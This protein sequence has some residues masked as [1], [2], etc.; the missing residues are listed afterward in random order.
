MLI[1]AQGKLI[2]RAV[3]RALASEANRLTHEV[4]RN[5]P[6]VRNLPEPL[7]PPCD[8]CFTLAKGGQAAAMLKFLL[9]KQGIEHKHSRPVAERE[10]KRVKDKKPEAFRT[11]V[12]EA[13]S[14]PLVFTR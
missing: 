10:A 14:L 2:Q 13:C 11:D 5:V 3:K 6:K 1:N 9:A 4:P 12:S 8:I 7:A